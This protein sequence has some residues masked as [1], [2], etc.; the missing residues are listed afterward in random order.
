MKHI[1]LALATVAL[2][3]TAPTALAQTFPS[4]PV[5]LIVP[6]PPGDGSDL[7]ARAI[8]Q[9][10][11]EAW[12]QPIVVE[13]RPGAGGRIGSEA[14]AKA[15]PDGYTWIMGN[16]GSHGINAAIYRNLPF[17]IERDFAPITQIMRAPNVLV[18]NPALGVNNVQDFLALLKKSPGKYSYGSGGNGSS[19]HMSAELFKIMSGVDLAHVPYK[20]G[21]P[22]LTD[23]IA[24]RVAMFLGNLPPAIGHISNGRV[25]ALAVTTRQRSPLL[26]DVPTLDEAG[27]KDFETIAWFGLLAPAGTPR[28][29]ID[30]I[31]AEVVRVLQLPSI[32]E[33]ILA[34]GGEPV[35]NRPEEF[36]AIIRSDIAKWK[37]VAEKANV[38]VE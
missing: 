33:S 15:A 14:A 25:K 8:G 11:S 22:A 24:G 13:N 29:I 2:P 32:R 20:G 37:K 21:T 10:L 36:A 9:K 1:L 38:R 4:K 19:S 7:V 16:A 23:L 31:R 12:G 6:S 28:Q 26:P 34:L 30:E 27:L 17:D 18:V 5:R 35:G 3:G